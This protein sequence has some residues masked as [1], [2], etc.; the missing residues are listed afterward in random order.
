[1]FETLGR[2]VYRARWSMLVIGLIVTVLSGVWGS[3]VF[4]QLSDGG[5]EDPRAPSTQ[6]RQIVDRW[7]GGGGADVVVLY[8]HPTLRVDDRRYREDVQKSLR[9]LPKEHVR[10]HTT[11]WG[12][13]AAELASN[14]RKATYAA[15]RLR[16]QDETARKRA[17]AAIRDRLDIPG[18]QVTVGG[19]VPL[20]DDLNAQTARDLT[21][22][23]LISLPLLLILLVVV[24]GSLVAA[25][26]PLVV[27]VV[28][29]AGAMALLRG[30]TMVTDV[31]VF[32]INVVTMLGLGL[33]ID[34]S[35]F[36]VS[37]FREEL[38][39]GADVEKAVVVTMRTAGRTVAFSG[40][41]VATSL[42]G[43]LFFPQ[44][45]LR[46]IG[47]GGAAVVVV[48]ML[49]ALLVLP[50]LLA[51]L[52]H[53]VDALRVRRARRPGSR[54]RGH[55]HGREPE[56]VWVRLGRSVMRQPVL[57]LAAVTVVLLGLAAPFLHV[58]FGGIDARV[59]P[60]HFE[61]RK[62]AQSIEEDFTR[63]AMAPIDVVVM[64][65]REF[66]GPPGKTP[67]PGAPTP[68]VMRT[69]PVGTED[70][71]KYLFR[72]RQ[73]NGVTGVQVTGVSEALGAVRLAVR[74]HTD[75]M[76]DATRELV[77]KIRGLY[78]EPGFRQVLVGGTTAAQLDLMASLTDTLPK[79][80]LFVFLVTAL[81]LFAAF[82][83][84]VLPLKAIVMN[85]LSLGASFGVIVWAFQDGNLADALGFTPTGTI[86]ATV[87]VL[88]L[89]VVFGLSMDY[90]LFL[91]S[92]VR[93]EWDRTRDNS[94]AVVRGLQHTGGII[95]S[96]ALL[97]LVVIAAFSTA[98][99]T[100]VKLLGVG[101]FVAIVV[102]AT[103][104]RALLVPATMRL[105]GEAN[106]W[107]PAP[108]RRLHDRIDLREHDPYEVSHEAFR[109]A[110]ITPVAW[111]H[112]EPEFVSFVRPPLLPSLPGTAYA[113]LPASPIRLRPEPVAVNGAS[114]ARPAGGGSAPVRPGGVATPPHHAPP[115]P[116]AP[117]PPSAPVPAA[118]EAPGVRPPNGHRPGAVPYAADPAEPPEAGDARTGAASR[119]APAASGTAEPARAPEPEK[120]RGQTD[121][122]PGKA[123]GGTA[124]RG[125]RE[126]AAAASAPGTAAGEGGPVS[127]E[128]VRGGT[129][130]P[131]AGRPRPGA[132]KAGPGAG[133]AGPPAPP[134]VEPFP[135]F[136]PEEFTVLTPPLPGGK[137]A[138]ARAGAGEERWARKVQRVVVPNED[139]PG[140]HWA[141]IV[142]EVEV[143][144]EVPP[145]P[146]PPRHDEPGGGPYD[147]G[148]GGGPYGEDAGGDAGQAGDAGAADPP[149]RGDPPAP[150][151]APGREPDGPAR[152]AEHR[153]EREAEP[154]GERE[155]L[156]DLLSELISEF[157]P[158]GRE[159]AAPPAR[160]G[161][162]P[163]RRRVRVVVPNADGPGWHWE[164]R[165]E[166]NEE[167]REEAGG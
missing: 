156:P 5:F 79:T 148:P 139:G 121:A 28:S 8:R 118:P 128:D 117:V 49:T 67:Y 91:L 47:V 40:L 29:I 155:P 52:G 152:A 124:E 46:S 51:V 141:E 81:L 41:T 93:A 149:G 100:V 161:T 154:G 1:M 133:K 71:G 12:G 122:T 105:M 166:E 22:A 9:A 72:L 63:N 20:L 85:V 129:A 135:P 89:A 136:G 78:D 127:G 106:W 65:E 13:K 82:G 112:P 59:L 31:S 70:V 50:A 111:P 39:A 164:E 150:A 144:V 75:P 87:T 43:L 114:A 95:T 162:T 37:R 137:A 130:E 115:A 7:F 101:L 15:I 116:C 126:D 53:R 97:L 147:A 17:Y 45:F 131:G 3:G 94:V 11:Y 69:S 54:R 99:I 33:A 27:G 48:A 60:E 4:G 145:P 160:P 35:L 146:S 142:E 6:V 24:F 153:G 62:V 38:R 104:V 14:D 74:Y 157:S 18:Y 86:E 80:G 108:L 66:T 77:T 25:A 123:P 56:G 10:R 58:R 26:T 143:G 84:L 163:G 120:T 165:E 21:R 134:R 102:D 68:E 109:Q 42:C 55:R 64:L 23:E 34:Y 16:G 2:L 167:E 158:E 61:S 140:W 119:Q 159:E 98:G 73:L 44:M 19:D 83:S 88:I 110:P 57:Y 92:R 138:G 103:L 132:G 125:A 76:S 90:E 107:L 113:A 36:V 30:L 151:N 32:A 96:A